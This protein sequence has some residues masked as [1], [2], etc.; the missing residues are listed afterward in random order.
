[1][2]ANGHVKKTT[3]K[4]TPL[5]KIMVKILLVKRL[6]EKD[7]VSPNDLVKIPSVG[8]SLVVKTSSF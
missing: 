8:K 1:V 3:T 6:R 7:K 5:T 2:S 4:N